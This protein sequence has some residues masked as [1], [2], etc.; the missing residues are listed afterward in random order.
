MLGHGVQAVVEAVREKKKEREGG[1]LTV[2]SRTEM[3]GCKEEVRDEF[4]IR[5]LG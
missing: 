4:W 1:R 2:D 3:E 5:L